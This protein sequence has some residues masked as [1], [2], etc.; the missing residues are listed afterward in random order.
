MKTQ[1]IKLMFQ[2]KALF[3]KEN[4]SIGEQETLLM[5]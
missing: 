1:D 2:M 4:W 3:S 5:L